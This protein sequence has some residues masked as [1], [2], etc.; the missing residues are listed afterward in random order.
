LT[1]VK[2]LVDLHQG[3]I[4]AFSEGIGKGSEFVVHLPLAGPEP[5]KIQPATE[6]VHDPQEPP[7][8]IL[9]VQDDVDDASSMAEVM[10]VW[11]YEVELA[12]NGP[13][14]I[15]LAEKLKPR[16]ILLDL[17]QSIAH[18]CQVAQA[19]RQQPSLACAPIVALAGLGMMDDRVQAQR[20]GIDY[21]LT[22]PIDYS[23]LREMLGACFEK[24]SFS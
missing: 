5:G 1:L 24:P 23:S 22:K 2:G 11:G 17:G 3:T 18:G 12:P 15:G 20:S 13:A 10:R 16:V 6:E 8:R 7:K 21:L 4:E 14:L 9:I 19:L